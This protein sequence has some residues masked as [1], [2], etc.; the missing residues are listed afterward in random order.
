MARFIW[1]LPR[2][3]IHSDQAPLVVEGQP[4][5]QGHERHTTLHRAGRLPGG[6]SLRGRGLPSRP[7]PA[8]GLEGEVQGGHTESW[9]LPKED[10]RKNQQQTGEKTLLLLRLLLCQ[11]SST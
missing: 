5:L 6:G 2:G 10:S 7:L 11:M 1:A 4:G 9:H 8:R 3:Q